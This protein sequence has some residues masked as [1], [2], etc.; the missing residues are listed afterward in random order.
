MNR[1]E[2]VDEH[3]AGI[4]D[5]RGKVFARVREIILA[6]QIEKRYTKREI[7]TIYCNQMY[8]GHG[9]YGVEAL[10]ARCPLATTFSYR[11]PFQAARPSSCHWRSACAIWGPSTVMSMSH[12]RSSVI[13]ARVPRIG[14]EVITGEHT[15]IRC[16]ACPS[17]VATR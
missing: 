9:A 8:L 15:L 3:I 16:R 2:R 6:V 1:S 7:F 4:K 5:W 13:S 11:G 10:A 14:V 17:L 12:A